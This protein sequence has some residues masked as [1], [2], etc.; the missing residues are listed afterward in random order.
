MRNLGF[1]F[2]VIKSGYLYK[3]RNVELP[4]NKLFLHVLNLLYKEGFLYGFF[5]NVKTNRV[6]IFLKYYNNRPLLGNIIKIS[7]PS[8]RRYFSYKNLKKNLSSCEI[9]VLSSTK[10]LAT[11]RDLLFG[12]KLGGEVLFIISI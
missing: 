8:Y 2:S 10:G 3:K 7:I 11:T 12:S 1:L 5:Y 4:C 6:K 9:L